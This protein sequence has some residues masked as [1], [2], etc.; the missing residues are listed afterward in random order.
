MDKSAEAYVEASTNAG[1]S[2]TSQPSEAPQRAKAG[3]S[4]QS[5][6]PAGPKWIEENQEVA[7]G[8]AFVLLLFYTMPIF[9]IA[10]AMLTTRVFQDPS[11][12]LSWFAA[13]MK[14]SDSTLG[15]FHKVLFPVMSGLSVIVFRDKP[16]KAMLV[17]GLFI[18]CLFAT[19]VGIGVV[20]DIPSTQKALSRLEDPINP[21]LA[22]AFFSHIQETL[23][24]Y[25]MMLIG[26]SVTNSTK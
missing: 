13:F 1:L 24:M 6:S 18:L 7:V 9:L 20:F 16:T 22:R 2:S 4:S 23:L 26:I 11:N 21:D 5:V 8:F 10:A 25:L 14:T 12:L 15:G 19:T 17:L 3:E